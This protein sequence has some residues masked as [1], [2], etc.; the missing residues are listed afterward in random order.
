[1][2]NVPGDGPGDSGCRRGGHDYGP[3]AGRRA[4]HPHAPV[5][6]R[7]GC[8]VTPPSFTNFVCRGN[9][10]RSPKYLLTDK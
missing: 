3:R 6:R 5:P 7:L 9:E 4:L 2:R 1:V 10:D 8:N